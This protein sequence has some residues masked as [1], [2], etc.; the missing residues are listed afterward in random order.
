MKKQVLLLAKILLI[1]CLLSACEYTEDQI[2]SALLPIMIPTEQS[3]VVNNDAPTPVVTE[4]SAVDSKKQDKPKYLFDYSPKLSLKLLGKKKFVIFFHAKWCS[5][6]AAWLKK[7]ADNADTLPADTI[8]LKADY[9]QELDLKK[10]LNV[11]LPSTVVYFNADGSVA[12][13]LVNSRFYKLV[14]FFM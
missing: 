3:N 6:C 7:V 4:M 8:I 11:K 2:I 9:D 10:A 1:T 5:S 14:A 13:I 12:D